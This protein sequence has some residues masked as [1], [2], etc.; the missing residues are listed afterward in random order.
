MGFPESLRPPDFTGIA[1]SL[2]RLVALGTTKSESLQ[3]LYMHLTQRKL[4]TVE[5]RIVYQVHIL[6]GTSIIM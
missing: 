6:K 2:E 5:M 4:T 1:F 3:H